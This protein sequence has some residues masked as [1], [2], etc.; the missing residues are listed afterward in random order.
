MTFSAYRPFDFLDQ[1]LSLGLE[2][3]F[4]FISF[5]SA[6]NGRMSA[7]QTELIDLVVSND[8]WVE[9]QDRL[10]EEERLRLEEEERLRLEEALA[11]E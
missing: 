10:A 5:E 9:E 6:Y 3:M 7:G 4:M 8:S 2:G 1:S 11:E